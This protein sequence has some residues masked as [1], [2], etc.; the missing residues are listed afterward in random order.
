MAKEELLAGFRNALDRGFSIEEAKHSFLNA[1]YSP[2]EVEEAQEI[3]AGSSSL[4]YAFQQPL[5]N[6]LSIDGQPIK[7]NSKTKIIVLIIIALLVLAGLIL[8]LLF[9]SQALSIIDNLFKSI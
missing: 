8:A 2:Q 5:P 3:I 9:K 1:G 7:K 4:P 6:Q